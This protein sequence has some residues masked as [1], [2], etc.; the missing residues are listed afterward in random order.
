MPRVRSTLEGHVFSRDIMFLVRLDATDDGAFTNGPVK[1]AWAHWNF[2]KGENSVLAL[3]VGQSK[4]YHGLEGT[5]TSEGM[6]FVDRSLATQAFGTVRSRGAWVHGKHN[7]NKIRWVAG[8]QNGD[9]GGGVTSVAE[10][11][12]EAP[13]ADNEL[14]FVGSVSFDPMGDITGGKNNEAFRMGDLNHDIKELQG[15][16]GAGVMLGNNSAVTGDVE[17]QAFNVNTAWAFGGGLTAQAE[18]YIRSDDP[19]VG[20]SEDTTG[21]VVLGTYT[22]PKSGDSPIQWGFGLR[23]SMISTDDTAVFLGGVPGDI[24]EITAVADAFYHGHACKSQFEYT[25]QEFDPD[26]TGSSTNHI[27]RLQFQLLF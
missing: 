2:S 18:V 17:A 16:I 3:R 27:L 15:T 8:V 12:E 23:A 11:G 1:D 4:P 14:N 24:L 22:L 13:N 25:M 7:E 5:S 26:A 6:Y 9:V 21:F 10:V 19:S 20:A